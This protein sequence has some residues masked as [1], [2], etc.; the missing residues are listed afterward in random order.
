MYILLINNVKV[1]ET[2]SFFYLMQALQLADTV[3]TSPTSKTSKG[4]KKYG[5]GKSTS[6]SKDRKSKDR[7]SVSY[8]DCLSDKLRE[9][10]VRYVSDF[11]K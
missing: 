3:T 9:N 6:K 4:V 11:W 8:Y 2:G 1:S 7:L 10:T 5:L